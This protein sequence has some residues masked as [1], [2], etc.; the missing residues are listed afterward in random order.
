MITGNDKIN[1]VINESSYLRTLSD[2]E[3]FDIDR[4]TYYEYFKK[5]TI[6][7]IAQRVLEKYGY[8]FMLKSH[9]NYRLE[10]LIIRDEVRR[11]KLTP[12]YYSRPDSFDI[13]VDDIIEAIKDEKEV[14]LSNP[15]GI[16]LESPFPMP[17]EED[18]FTYRMIDDFY[19]EE[20]IDC[21]PVE[22]KEIEKEVLEAF[23][24]NVISSCKNDVQALIDEYKL[25]NKKH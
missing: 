7:R 21:S 2:E 6:E 15:Y 13:S 23:F 9:N 3:L 8:T 12:T 4:D 24:D 17:I 22:E 5:D 1:K 19:I 18:F 20:G 10:R 11:R 25:V 16:D 14:A